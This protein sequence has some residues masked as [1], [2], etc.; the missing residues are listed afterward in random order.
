[1]SIASLDLG[2]SRNT[3]SINSEQSRIEFTIPICYPIQEKGE[4]LK[5]TDEQLKDRVLVVKK[6][7]NFP[8]G[9]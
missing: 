3:K 9:Y 2:H 5:K 4:E 8:D 7:S 1:M 6:N